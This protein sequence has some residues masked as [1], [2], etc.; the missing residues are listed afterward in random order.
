MSVR[1]FEDLRIWKDSMDLVETVYGIA[2][3][4][5]SEEIFGLSSQLK[6]ATVSISSNIAEGCGCATDKGF[7]NYLHNALGSTKEVRCQLLIA[8]RLGF[9]NDDANVVDMVD[10]LGG[11]IMRLIEKVVEED[12]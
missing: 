4:F 3:G 8:I 12:V 6:R 7:V 10:K 5:P 2:A 1:K 9:F 11:M